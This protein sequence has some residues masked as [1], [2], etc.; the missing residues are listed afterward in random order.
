M[1]CSFVR[2]FIQIKERFFPQITQITRIKGQE[3]WGAWG[4][5]LFGDLYKLKSAFFPQ[6]TQ[7]SQIK[8]QER[9]GAWGVLMCNYGG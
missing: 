9:Q 6:I 7:I 8:G 1:G 4:V 3:H 5:L 2:G